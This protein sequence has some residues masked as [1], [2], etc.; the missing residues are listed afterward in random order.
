MGHSRG[1]IET[2]GTLSSSPFSLRQGTMLA[3][4][5]RWRCR[6]AGEELKTKFG[7]E[8]L[9]RCLCVG[10]DRIGAGDH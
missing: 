1:V 3:A 4:S 8:L 9:K 6:K 2:K 5:R 7:G 10:A